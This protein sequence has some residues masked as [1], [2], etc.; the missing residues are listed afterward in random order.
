MDEGY[1]LELEWNKDCQEKQS[2]LGLIRS[3][4]KDEDEVVMALRG[5]CDATEDDVFLFQI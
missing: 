3:E 1:L 4:R 2:I 5:D